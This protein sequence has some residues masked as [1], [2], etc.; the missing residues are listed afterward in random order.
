[1]IPGHSFEQDREIKDG[2][3]PYFD[4]KVMRLPGT[5]EN[6]NSCLQQAMQQR[7]KEP[8]LFCRCLQKEVSSPGSFSYELK[9][10]AWCP[11]MLLPPVLHDSLALS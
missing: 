1:M 4:A 3:L 11:W 10:K 7:G 5:S 8:A 2:F 9:R 6:I